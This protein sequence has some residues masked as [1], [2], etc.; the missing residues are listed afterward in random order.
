MRKT[1]ILVVL[2]SCVLGLSCQEQM[3]AAFGSNSGITIVTTPRCEEIAKDLAASLEREIVT[4]Q[5]E[6]AYDVTLIT[7]GDVKNHDSRKNIIVIDFLEP[8]NRL[9]KTILDLAGGAREDV[10]AGKTAIFHRED[11]WAMG[12]VVVGITAPTKAALG[13]L[14]TGRSEDIFKYIERVVQARLNRAIFNAGEQELVTER[15]AST[16]G[17]SLRLPPRYEVDEKYAAERVIKIL[18]DK[19]ARMITVYW[20]DGDWG[21]PEA[22]C[23]ERKR[24][25]AWK[26]WDED[27]IVEDALEVS[28]GTF[29]GAPAVHLTGTWENKKY[30]IGGSFTSYC[31]T[32]P[33]CGRNYFIDAAVFAPGF[34]KLPL[35]RELEAILVTFKCSCGD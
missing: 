24:M 30:V 11:R 3:I 5:Y 23:V 12:Q 20:E 31:F 35:M 22:T 4:V 33:D 2:L 28:G 1:F 10:R 25:L 34:D 19:P 9:S 32:C 7:T 26:Y 8:E 14:V 18:Q 13:E 21:E 15:L 17:W 16:Y 29:V 27:E 6:R